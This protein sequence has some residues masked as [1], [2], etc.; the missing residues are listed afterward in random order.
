MD[1]CFRKAYDIRNN[2]KNRFLNGQ[3]LQPQELTYAWVLLSRDETKGV[4]KV[5][6]TKHLEGVPDPS[7]TVISVDQRHNVLMPCPLC[8][9]EEF[10]KL[11]NQQKADFLRE[12]PNKELPNP[13]EIIEVGLQKWEQKTTVK[14]TELQ[15]LQ[16]EFIE[17]NKK[18][19]LADGKEFQKLFAK[20]KELYQKIEHLKNPI[21]YQVKQER[22]KQQKQLEANLKNKVK[23]TAVQN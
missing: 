22:L 8:R 20:S 10:N 11:R 21:D 6:P 3:P 1:A 15:K 23:V 16:T 7:V 13:M 14:Q 9:R 18:V 17:V 4:G 2:S 5:C 19:H 12:N